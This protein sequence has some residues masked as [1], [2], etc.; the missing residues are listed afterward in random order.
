LIVDVEQ[1]PEYFDF[2]NR[3]LNVRFDP[4]MSICIASLSDDGEIYG[5]VVY[6]RFCEHTCELSVASSNPKFLTRRFLDAVFHY[7]FITA[8]KTRISAVIE[9]G[10]INALQM[11]LR[12]GFVEEARLVGWYGAKDG[13]MLRML[14]SE[15]KWIR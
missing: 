7:P 14:R 15:C 11:D 10:N 8:K 5:V 2:I 9:D 1:R 3:I 13:I 4:A 12:L 6:S